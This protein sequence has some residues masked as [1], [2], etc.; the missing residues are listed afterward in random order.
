MHTG[1]PTTINTCMWSVRRMKNQFSNMEEYTRR[2]IYQWC[3]RL[4][5]D[6]PVVKFRR[7][8]YSG[9]CDFTDHIITISKYLLYPSR[10][11]D[12]EDTCRHEVLH[13]IN[14]THDKNFL[15]FAQR[16]GMYR[17]KTYEEF[18]KEHAVHTVGWK[19]GKKFTRIRYY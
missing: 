5:V 8:R 19:N 6:R 13:L 15:E 3:G 12:L 1:R 2:Y 18:R 14:A 16:L 11:F 10:R 7:M 17:G 4:G 9:S